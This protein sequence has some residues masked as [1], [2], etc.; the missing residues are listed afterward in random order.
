VILSS[1]I[2]AERWSMRRIHEEVRVHMASGEPLYDLDDDAITAMRPTVVFTQGLCPVCA[3]TADDVDS[4][5]CTRVVTLTPHSIADVVRDIRTIGAVLDRAEAANALAQSFEDRIGSVRAPKSRP[6]VL[7]LEWFDPPWISGEWIPEMVI[8]AGGEPL[9][10]GPGDPSR[11]V[12]WD[13]IAASDPDVVLLAACS[14]TVARTER[15]LGALD[16]QPAWKN[17]RAVREGRVEVLDG[18]TQFSA[19]GPGLAAG[20]ECIA[21]VL[22]KSAAGSQIQA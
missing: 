8:A 19:P 13:E 18:A 2:D 1:R 5:I 12:T 6:R 9:I 17:L 14:M 16:A 21:Q 4:K 11:Q 10:L 7:V 22:G 20:V 3:A 15:E